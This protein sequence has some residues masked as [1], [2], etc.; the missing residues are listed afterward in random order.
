MNSPKFEII[1]QGNTPDQTILFINKEAFKKTFDQ[2]SAL[3]R[4]ALGAELTSDKLL[5]SF[6]SNKESFYSCLNQ[7]NILIG[8]LLGFGLENSLY[9][10]RFEQILENLHQEKKESH[11]RNM[12]PFKLNGEEA[13]R[14]PYLYSKFKPSL[15]Y[16]SL[17]EEK[18]KLNSHV[19]VSIAL[20]RYSPQLLFGKLISDDSELVK[21]YEETQ[22]KLIEILNHPQWMTEV[23]SHFY[24]QPVKIRIVE[25][26]EKENADF[27]NFSPLIAQAIFYHFMDAIGPNHLEKFPDLIEGIKEA[28]KRKDAHYIAPYPYDMNN[29][30]STKN[31]AFFLGFIDWSFYKFNNELTLP[32]II[33]QLENLKNQDSKP[34][35]DKLDQVYWKI[36]NAI[37]I[38]E[39]T[40]AEID[41]KRL[42]KMKDVKP[43]VNN[44]LY[45]QIVKSGKGTQIKK[46]STIQI[47]YTLKTIT[48]NIIEDCSQGTSLDLERAIKGFADGFPHMR[49]GDEGI[50]FIH[51]EWGIKDYFSP[52]YF[53]PYLIAE[54]Q[55]KQILEKN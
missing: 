2:H 54:F 52:P 32:M 41:F 36:F 46:N 33:N 35:F 22:L 31:E 21:Q 12:F 55:I 40:F 50:L 7:D 39:K 34:S 5:K 18:E 37:D 23:L 20:A 10:G 17:E 15:G 8:I 24:G 13:F 11:H 26:S 47:S 6:K 3:F 45:Y 51:P 38:Y 19:D 4:Y 27:S 43:L 25:L 44:R 9:V 53:F 29:L 30:F 1:L 42:E 28:D 49:E 14:P 48:G 16:Q